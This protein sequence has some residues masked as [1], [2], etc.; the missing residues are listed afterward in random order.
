MAIA[1]YLRFAMYSYHFVWQF[2]M[3][4]LMIKRRLTEV[5]NGLEELF[6]FVSKEYPLVNKQL[7]PQC[8]METNLPTPIW[9]G[10]C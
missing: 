8:L 3:R 5:Q 1:G 9:Q 10:L 6:V 4:T 2:F 7:D